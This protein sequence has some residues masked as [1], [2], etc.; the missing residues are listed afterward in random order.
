[1]TQIDQAASSLAVPVASASPPSTDP[2][3]TRPALVW[4]ASGL[5][6]AGV[7]IVIAA[8]LMTM[9]FSIIDF[10][11]SCTLGTVFPT[12]L[13]DPLR[14]LFAVIMW[15]AAVGTATLA[16]ITAYYSWKGYAWTRWFGLITVAV[17]L[18]SFTMNWLAP[19]CLVPLAIGAGMLWLPPCR[20]FFASCA[21]QPA[22]VPATS[23]TSIF[24]GP[25]P[26][27]FT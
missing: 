27:Y 15:I 12:P 20:A 24:Y 25:A 9:W 21:P 1:M 5:L 6:Y 22:D 2:E 10:T 19:I 23:R 7:G 13:G 3:A 11:S 26:R 18:S 17:G 4:V 8:L 16:S 14:I